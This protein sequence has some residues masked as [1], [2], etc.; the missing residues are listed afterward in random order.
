MNSKFSEIFIYRVFPAI[1]DEEKKNMT[2]LCC[3]K[4]LFLKRSCKM[5]KAS[6]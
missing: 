2:E 5:V 4:R 3:R 6:I 1:A